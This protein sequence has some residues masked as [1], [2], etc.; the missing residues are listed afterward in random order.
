MARYTSNDRLNLKIGVLSYSEN[1]TS[2]EVVG[3]LGIGTDSAD[4]PLHVEGGAYINNGALEVSDGSSPTL[5]LDAKDNNWPAI[6]FKGKP[7][8]GSA[9]T[10]MGSVGFGGLTNRQLEIYSQGP[11]ALRSVNA[12]GARGLFVNDGY[13]GIGI[14]NP[15]AKLEVLEDSSD[16]ALR[17]TQTGSGNALVV[18]DSANPDATPFVIDNA[19]RIGVGTD[20]P[21]F[22]LHVFNSGQNNVVL[23]ESGDPFSSFGLSDSNGSV[24]FLTTLGKLSIRT[25]GDAGTVGTNAIESLVIKSTGEVGIGTDNPT[26][27]LDVNGDI[28]VSGVITTSNFISTSTTVIANDT[29]NVF[30]TSGTFTATAGITADIDTFII[31]TN[32]FK[33]TEYTLH[34]INGSNIQAQKVLVMQNGTSAYSQ[35]YA[36]M[37]EPNQIVSIGATVSSGT[38]KLQVTPE[39]GISGLTTYKF[40]RNSLL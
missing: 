15:T 6:I 7:T 40:S 16:D 2:L 19:G 36:I 29:L 32:D 18:Q 26:A 27:K 11:V 3:R 33:T 28:N 4:Q 31:S 39:T 8:G 24:S 13:I 1:L 5:W 35:E 38:F 9:G 37:Y 34:F 25:G 23:F 21:N 22:P 17:I 20:N 30:A 10:Q 12:S 14:E